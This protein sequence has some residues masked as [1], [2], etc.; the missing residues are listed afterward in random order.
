MLTPSSSRVMLVPVAGP[1]KRNR[2]GLDV[3]FETPGSILVNTNIRALINVRTFSAFPPQSQQQL[4]QLL[5]EVD[6]QV[7]L[8]FDSPSLISKARPVDLCS[9]QI[10]PDGMARLSSSAL[11]NEFFTHA[12]QS[13][14]ERLAE[15]MPPPPPPPLHW[16][17]WYW[18]LL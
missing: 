13:W 10:G 11:N 18:F 14:K 15:G 9:S 1:M 5:P 17:N 2:G 7:H 8:F 12:S 4:L 16:A 3:D 6:R